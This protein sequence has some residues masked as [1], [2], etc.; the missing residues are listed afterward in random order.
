M[1]FKLK[2]EEKISDEKWERKKFREKEEQIMKE[3]EVLSHD[4]EIQMQ[5]AQEEMGKS[6]KV[7][8]VK[9]KVK[10][11]KMKELEKEIKKDKMLRMKKMFHKLERQAKVI[12]QL[13]VN[14]LDIRM[15]LKNK[16]T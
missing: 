16:L 12:N 14:E 1:K 11:Q 8:K 6:T 13:K 9:E 10:K 4:L 5:L 15:Q 3:I 7:R 2:K